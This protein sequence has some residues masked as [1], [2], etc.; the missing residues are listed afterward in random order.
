MNTQYSSIIHVPNNQLT[1]AHLHLRTC[2]DTH[3]FLKGHACALLPTHPTTAAWV[4]SPGCP[5]YNAVGLTAY[6]CLN[7]Y[8]CL[9]I[10]S[11]TEATKELLGL[12]R[13]LFI[14]V[15]CP[16]KNKIW[17]EIVLHKLSKK[18]YPNNAT[19]CKNLLYCLIIR[20]GPD[21]TGSV[22]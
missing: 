8:W 3:H 18:K 13:I 7:W 16:F 5:L 15:H 20:M 10:M 21:N 4:E 1:L 22:R 19:D 12:R 17:F 6:K 11:S 9:R 2:S 14:S